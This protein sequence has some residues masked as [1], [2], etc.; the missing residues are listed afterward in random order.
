MATD[1]LLVPLN[2]SEHANTPKVA[3]HRFVGARNEPKVAIATLGGH[4]LLCGDISSASVVH[5]CRVF[6][7]CLV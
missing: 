5:I 7:V 4:V 3:T 6:I 2:I 1:P